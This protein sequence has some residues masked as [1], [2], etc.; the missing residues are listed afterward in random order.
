MTRTARLGI[1]L[2]GR[3]SNFQALQRAVASG[4]IEAE[5][6]LV[7]SNVEGA[8]GIETARSLGL[9]TVA[10][11]HEGRKRREHDLLV[12]EALREAEVDWICLAGYMRILSPAFVEAFP[13]RIVNIHPSLLPSFP[14]LHAQ[15]Q[16][17]DYGVRVSGCTVHLVDDGLD[18]GP[19]VAQAT[20]P[21][22]GCADAEELSA[23]ILSQEHVLYP[24]AMGRLLS[25]RWRVAGRRVV[26]G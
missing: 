6:A 15:E 4:D 1:L 5:I 16:A 10:I 13:E 9:A 25:E 2:S 7:V 3:G 21:V 24:R 8:P 12:V 26:F 11:P 23:R 17:W 20:V 14:G 19:I 18:S 22:D